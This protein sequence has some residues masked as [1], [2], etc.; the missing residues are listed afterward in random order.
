MLLRTIQSKLHLLRNTWVFNHVQPIVMNKNTALLFVL[1]TA[2]AGGLGYYFLIRRS[3][4][5]IR[6]DINTLVPANERVGLDTILT[7]MSRQELL[8]TEQLVKATITGKKLND[9]ALEQRLELISTR[10]NIFT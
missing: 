9:P 7:K 4:Q 1:L 5:Q 2:G 6:N 10:Y 8:D 3:D